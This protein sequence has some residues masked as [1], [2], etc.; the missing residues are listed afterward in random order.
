MPDEWEIFY[1]VD[2]PNG[3]P[4]NDGDTNLEE[5][6]AR[7]NPRT[8]AASCSASSQSS[9]AA[10]SVVITFNGVAGRTFRSRAQG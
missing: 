10:T 5:Y 6:G 7:T 3:D 4:D 2:D 8:M 9:A 1:G